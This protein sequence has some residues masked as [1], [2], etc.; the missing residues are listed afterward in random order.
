MQCERG[1]S[2]HQHGAVGFT[3]VP[4][5]PSDVNMVSGFNIHIYMHFIT[6]LA[7]IVTL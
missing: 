4:E 6:M 1:A 2:L 3:Q 5:P 7:Q